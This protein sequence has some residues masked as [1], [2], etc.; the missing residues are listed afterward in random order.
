MFAEDITIAID[1]SGLHSL[2]EL[3]RRLRSRVFDWFRVNDLS[4]SDDESQ[5]RMFSLQMF[6][7]KSPETTLSSSLP[8]IWNNHVD[9]IA[10]K[11]IREV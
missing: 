6:E 10:A 5:E 9:N 8:C 4:V 1:S 7:K 3:S 2:Y 11:L